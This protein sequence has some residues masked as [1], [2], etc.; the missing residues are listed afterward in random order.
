VGDFLAS[1]EGCAAVPQRGGHYDIGLAV[2]GGPMDGI[3][4]SKPLHQRLHTLLLN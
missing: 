4:V 3:A 1:R 2:T